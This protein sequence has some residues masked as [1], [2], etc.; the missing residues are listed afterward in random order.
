MKEFRTVAPSKKDAQYKQLYLSKINANK[1][2]I[3]FDYFNYK[4]NELD[5]ML[6]IYHQ[7]NDIVKIT[8][9]F[10]GESQFYI[11]KLKNTW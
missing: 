9:D 3:K 11:I 1:L 8:N 2:P 7:K 4:Q 10:T 5:S 6:E